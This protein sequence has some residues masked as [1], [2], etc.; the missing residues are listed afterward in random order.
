MVKVEL[1]VLH[2]RI[3]EASQIL[4]ISTAAEIG[5][6]CISCYL[7]SAILNGLCFVFIYVGQEI[8]LLIRKFRLRLT[9]NMCLNGLDFIGLGFRLV[10]TNKEQ[11]RVFKS[12]PS[13]CFSY[14]SLLIHLIYFS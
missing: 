7:I 1:P 2:S 10:E 3:T 9:I 13:I 14:F 5:W 6:R 4:I 11:T 12:S 8:D